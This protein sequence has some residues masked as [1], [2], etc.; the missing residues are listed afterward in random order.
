MNL[1]YHINKVKNKYD[2]RYD[3]LKAEKALKKKEHPVM[4]KTL[5]KIVRVNISQNNNSH[6][7]QTDSQHHIWWWNAQSISSKMRNKTLDTFIQHSTGSCKHSNQENKKKGIHIWKKSKTA[8]ICQW[9]TATYSVCI[10]KMLKTSP[11][12][13]ELLNKFSEVARYKINIYKSVTFL[14]S[15]NKLSEK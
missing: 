15:N 4:I 14:C 9:H 12:L 1:I 3:H 5:S 11:K 10:R 6:I 13:L 8:T 2:L 7:G